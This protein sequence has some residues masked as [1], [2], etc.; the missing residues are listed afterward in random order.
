MKTAATIFFL[1]VGGVVLLR[2]FPSLGDLINPNRKAFAIALD[3]KQIRARYPNSFQL[4]RVL[5]MDDGFSCIY[6][7]ARY[8]VV[9]GVV[10]GL[11]GVDGGAIAGQAVV[12]PDGSLLIAPNPVDSLVARSLGAGALVQGDA[13]TLW[14]QHCAYRAGRDLTNDVANHLAGFD[15]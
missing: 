5:A 1:I 10:T 4:T 13:S 12:A 9:P 11:F 6:F 2:M 14:S 15:Q 8:G 7:N 3:V